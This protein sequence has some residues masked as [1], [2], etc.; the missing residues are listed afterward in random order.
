MHV[1]AYTE[2]WFQWDPR[3]ARSNL[4]K[5]KVSFSDAVGVFEDQQALT[6]N[7]PH[8]AEERYVTLGL[9]FIGRLPV[10]SWTLRADDIR[11]ISAQ[12]ATRRER[13]DYERNG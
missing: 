9:D 11:L 1:C 6:V 13:T 2:A 5:H 7:D 8:P 3:K 12:A 10:V 4:A